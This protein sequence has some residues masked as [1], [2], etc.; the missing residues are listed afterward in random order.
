MTYTSVNNYLQGVI[1]GHKF[2]GVLPPSVS[3]DAVKL[4]LMGFKNG[5]VL[6]IPRD[7]VTLN[8]LKSMFACLE[9][10]IS[11]QLMFWAAILLLFRSLL[12]IV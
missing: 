8:H 12:C 6:P 7:P 3:S 4:A 2:K 11:S 9:V 5:D 1:L 10:K